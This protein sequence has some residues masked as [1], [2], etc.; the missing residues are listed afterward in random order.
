MAKHLAR[1]EREKNPARLKPRH[2][3]QEGVQTRIFD[4][5]LATATAQLPKL[6]ED[7]LE[8]IKQ[9]CVFPGSEHFSDNKTVAPDLGAFIPRSV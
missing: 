2:A 8:A 1:L 4:E 7:A 5:N 6:L 9:V 3:K